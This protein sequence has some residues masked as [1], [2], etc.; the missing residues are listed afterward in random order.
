LTSLLSFSD[1]DSQK[2]VA[3]A[4]AKQPDAVRLLV[5]MLGPIVHGRIAKALFRRRGAG[6]GRNV[7]QEVEDLSQGVFLALFEE[8]ARAL[9]AWDPARSPLGAFVCLLAD[10]HVHSVFRSGKRRP[11]S[12]D[13][14]VLPE[15]DARAE[16]IHGPEARFASAEAIEVLLSRLRA[17]LSP[18]GFD[19]FARLYVEEQS[20]ETVANELG[21]TP[22]ALYAWRSRLSRLVRRL[23][24]EVDAPLVSDSTEPR[25]IQKEEAL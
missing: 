16:D 2:L 3:R 25:R 9:R 22:D 8:D 5:R 23:A 6:Q 21:M 15:P 11:W 7:A 20:V 19:V 14:D 17:E 18:K 1:Q 12:D 13:L 10:H 4:V 24:S